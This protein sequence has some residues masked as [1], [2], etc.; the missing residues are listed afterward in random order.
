M[1]FFGSLSF[2]LFCLVFVVFFWFVAVG[3]VFCFALSWF[4]L[5][6]FGREVLVARG[7]KKGPVFFGRLC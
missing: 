7:Y 3:V 4:S 1:F 5:V 6:F 2:F